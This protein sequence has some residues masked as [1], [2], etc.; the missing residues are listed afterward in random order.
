MISK[1]LYVLTPV[2]PGELRLIE[3]EMP[4]IKETEES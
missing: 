1:S 2:E 3:A 4:V